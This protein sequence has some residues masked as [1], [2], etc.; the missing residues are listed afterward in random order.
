[1]FLKP[2]WN[3]GT[4]NSQELDAYN[5]VGGSIGTYKSGKKLNYEIGA[6]FMSNTNEKIKIGLELA[7]GGLPGFQKQLPSR[8]A[9][10][11]DSIAKTTNGTYGSLS[12]KVQL[13]LTDNLQSYLT[14]GLVKTTS[15]QQFLDT[16]MSGGD[17]INEKWFTLPTGTRY[18]IG[19][20]YKIKNNLFA[21]ISYGKMEYDQ[22]TMEYLA[23]SGDIPRFTD[24]LEYEQI[25]LGLRY[26][27]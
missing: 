24:S 14:L 13:N 10:P 21:D 7:V 19:T 8:I 4:G 1:M 20:Q 22:H 12:G 5:P 18:T 16:N 3:E 9:F 15:D 25:I 26:K 6:D 2:S 17:K 11:D 23:N 27:F